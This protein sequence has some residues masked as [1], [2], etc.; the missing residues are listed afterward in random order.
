MFDDPIDCPDDTA[1][2]EAGPSEMPG[3]DQVLADFDREGFKPGD[4]VSDAWISHHLRVTAPADLPVGMTPREAISA[5]DRWQR[6][7]TA[8]VER[9]R[10][11]RKIH[12]SSVA[13][14]YVVLDD[15]AV[16]DHEMRKFTNA[17]VAHSERTAQR[18]ELVKTDTLSQE[19]R[20]R[21]VHQK[22][23][24]AMFQRTA[25]PKFRK[26]IGSGSGST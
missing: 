5:R 17:I 10:S 24:L 20:D 16:G 22:Q 14:G 1:A 8:F 11:D 21:L 9:V 23:V 15:R 25:L 3:W 6:T 13:D 12:M 2:A 18:L 26:S 19:E 7:C 4:V